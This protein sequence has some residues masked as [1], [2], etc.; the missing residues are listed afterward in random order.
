MP[1]TELG[2]YHIDTRDLAGTIN[3]CR[4]VF[5]MT[6]GSRPTFGIPS[7]WMCINGRAVIL[8]NEV[9]GAKAGETGPVDHVAFEAEAFESKCERLR[10][11]GTSYDVVGSRPKG[12]LRQIYLRDPNSFYIELGFQG[13]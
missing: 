5:G 1:V 10:Q 11:F 4:D 2:H 7:A 9:A 6:L 13:A 12:P 8:V 3:L